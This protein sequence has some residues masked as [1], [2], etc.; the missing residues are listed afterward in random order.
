MLE[1][2]Y[3]YTESNK[4]IIEKIIDDENINLNHVILP[5]GEKLPEHYTNSNVYLIITKGSMT[6]KLES[7]EPAVYPH[8]AFVNIPFNTKMNLSNQGKS[9]LEFFIVKSPNPKHFKA[10]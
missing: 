8:H 5:P 7:Q 9:I 4:K 10:S 1:K 3:D 6:L 2:K